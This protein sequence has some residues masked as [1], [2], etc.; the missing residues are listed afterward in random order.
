MEKPLPNNSNSSSELLPG[1]LGMLILKTLAGGAMHGAAIANSIHR[2]SEGV[3]RVEEG[4]LYPALH[5][6]ESQGW[7]DSEWGLSENNR[8]AKFYR[9]TGAGAKKLEDE[10]AHWQRVVTAIAKI[11][12]TVTDREAS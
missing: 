3:L 5:R 11:M 8:R 10:N 1:T 12:E 4:A 6:L 7:L 2:T 9:L